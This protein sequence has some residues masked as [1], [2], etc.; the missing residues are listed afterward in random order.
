MC[1]CIGA[2]LTQFDGV[3][4]CNSVVQNFANGTDAVLQRSSECVGRV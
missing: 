1:V 3:Q 4:L 2:Y